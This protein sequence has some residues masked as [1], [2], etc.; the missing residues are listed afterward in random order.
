MPELGA[1]SSLA[2]GEGLPAQVFVPDDV[3]PKTTT[4]LRDVP[5]PLGEKGDI[6][7][8]RAHNAQAALL[9]GLA[10][11]RPTDHM[12]LLLASLSRPKE[13]GLVLG[14]LLVQSFMKKVNPMIN[15]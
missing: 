12:I 5:K 9:P 1:A 15:M 7:S 4:A 10:N 2:E 8:L 6:H 13:S 3:E 11:V 14:N